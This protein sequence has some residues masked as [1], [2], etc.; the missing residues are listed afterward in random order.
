MIQRI[1]QR[2]HGEPMNPQLE[3]G[4]RDRTT[5]GT[6]A[7][8]DVTYLARSFRQFES[9]LERRL[10]A[11]FSQGTGAG[12]PEHETDVPRLPDDSPFGRFV[13][14]HAQDEESR[15]LVLLAL[16][17]AM[18]PDFFD[19]ILQGVSL[20]ASEYPEVGGVR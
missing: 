4:L 17:P 6:R 1:P 7:S 16:A 2:E 13:R 5:S 19:R 14:E 20:G 3:E 15:L 11:Q 10:R 12:A 9:A 18:K 8:P